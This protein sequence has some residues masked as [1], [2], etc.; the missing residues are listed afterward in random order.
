[1]QKNFGESK[2]SIMMDASPLDSTIVS[3]AS[4]G[5]VEEDVPNPAQRRLSHRLARSQ[6]REPKTLIVAESSIALF[7]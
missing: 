7:A 5:T 2:S 4:A 6:R 1:M 3:D